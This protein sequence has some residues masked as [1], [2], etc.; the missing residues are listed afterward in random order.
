MMMSAGGRLRTK[1][2]RVGRATLATAVAAVLTVSM[3]GCFSNP[4]D[5]L[6]DKVTEQ[7]AGKLVEQATGGKVDI[8]STGE[9]PKDFPAEVPLV[10]TDVISSF[11][12]KV[13]DGKTWTVGVRGSGSLDQVSKQV[14]DGFAQKGWEE[15]SWSNIGSELSG[16][17]FTSEAHETTAA[18]NIM[19]DEDTGEVMVT[20]VVIESVE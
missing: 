2:G 17:M 15:T 18:V 16:G 9:M 6:M 11:S 1:A 7:G 20:Y 5:K 12:M 3:S 8:G 13:D 10:S 14:K 4:V 19:A